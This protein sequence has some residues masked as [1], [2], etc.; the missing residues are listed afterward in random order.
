MKGNQYESSDVYSASI[1]ADYLEL[2]VE[3][4]KNEF[5]KLVDSEKEI[6]VYEYVDG[7]YEITLEDIFL[8]EDENS[9]VILL[10][11]TLFLSTNKRRVLKY[12]HIKF[13]FPLQVIATFDSIT[14]F[15]V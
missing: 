1:I 6:Y 7:E 2:D 10:I 4:F 15:I 9:M 3:Q 13:P 11:L 14:Y 12:F 8:G 5:N